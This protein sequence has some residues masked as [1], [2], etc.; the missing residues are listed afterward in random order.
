VIDLAIV[1]FILLGAIVGF[2]KGFVVPLAAAGG[3]LLTLAA[4]YAGPFTGVLPSGTAGLGLGAIA[5]FVGGTLFT[6][7]ATFVVGIVHRVGFLRRFDKVLGIPLGMVTAAVTLYVAVLATLVLDGWLDPL[8]GKTAFGPQDIAALQSVAGANPT[9]AAFADPQMLKL[10][11]QSAAKAPLASTDFEKVDGAIAFYEE[12]VRPELLS[13]RIVPVLL[14]IGE[15]LPF[16]GR[17]AVLPA[18]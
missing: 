3:A 10:M 7:V 12:K 15:K 16:I 5:L 13:S 9:F 17:P 18:R 2:G 4:L 1:A 8:H 14:A 11:A 6:T